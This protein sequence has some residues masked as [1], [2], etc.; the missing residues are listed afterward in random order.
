[1]LNDDTLIAFSRDAEW[2]GKGQRTFETNC[3]SCHG[4]DLTG[5]IG[6][7]LVDATWL[8]GGKPT[9]IFHTITNGVPEK[10]MQSWQGQ[11]SPKQIAE[12]AAFILSKQS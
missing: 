3:V 9:E 10:G 2:I 5:G 1:M 7:N 8:H 6:A 4:A 11:L 12:L